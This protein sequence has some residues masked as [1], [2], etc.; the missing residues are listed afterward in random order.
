MKGEEGGGESDLGGVCLGRSLGS[1]IDSAAG[2]D[3]LV[4]SA[5]V[6]VSPSLQRAAGRP[7]ERRRRCGDGGGGGGSSG[8]GD[9]RMAITAA[10]VT[11]AAAA[12]M[13]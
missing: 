12:R 8:G 11:V 1:A 3:G 7:L 10:V 13:V 5:S 2:L 6:Q 9:A 4:G